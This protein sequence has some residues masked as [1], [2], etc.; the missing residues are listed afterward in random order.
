MALRAS[1]LLTLG[2]FVV[3]CSLALPVAAQTNTAQKATAEAY[4][5]DALRLMQSS[6]FAEAC[7][8][9]E[10][11]QRLDPAVGTLLYLG[12]CYE[13]RGR[14]AS[15]WV[16]FREAEALARATSQP[17]R[18]EM[19]RARV[20]RLQAGLAKVTVEVSAEARAIP[21]LRVM[22][23][24][25]PIDPTLPGVALPVDPG[26]LVVEAS[27]PGYAP[28]T[29]TL[30]VPAAGKLSVQV[31]ALS[32]QAGPVAS[33]SGSA[34]AAPP[35]A[36]AVSPASSPAPTQSAPPSAEPSK[37]S[38]AW[39]IALGAVGIVGIGVG[40]A[41]G[42]RAIGKASDANDLCPDGQCREERGTSLMDSARSSANISNVAFAVGAVALVGGV[43]FYLVDKPKDA[44]R[45]LGLGTWVG[46]DRA[47]LSL[48]GSL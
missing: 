11:S 32:R 44:D 48:R 40:T 13:R 27:A 19:A 10:A 30:L 6:S 23:G 42:L 35:F 15:A 16:T 17:Q 5:D 4:F 14:T 36:T 1:S 38:L 3:A 47:G 33:S 21:A 41:F 25:V 2:T 45:S 12:E 20:D 37:Q 28:F 8:K 26:E 18:A 7:P 43:V 29:K 24:T 9:L 39:P 22:C 34:S 46:A 31:P